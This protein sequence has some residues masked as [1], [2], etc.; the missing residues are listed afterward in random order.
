MNWQNQY[1]DL[2][3]SVPTH[4]LSC[5]SRTPSP[6]EIACAKAIIP[7]ANIIL[8]CGSGSG[9]HILERAAHDPHHFYVG[10]EQRFKRAFK[11][12]EKAFAL[13]LK[14]ILFLRTDVKNISLFLDPSSVSG[15]FINFPDP[16]D[17]KKWN[18]HR[19]LSP[20]MLSLYATLLIGEGFIRYKTDHVGYFEDTL[21]ILENDHRFEI[22]SKTYNLHKSA[23]VSDNICSEFELLFQSKGVDVCFLEAKRAQTTVTN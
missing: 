7:K 21:K 1:I 15:I 2:C 8:E 5:Q 9:K 14:N 19:M 10:I 17:R 16:W 20:D 13:G 6:D 23:H 18:K 3:K 11:S 4:L 12:A 22:C